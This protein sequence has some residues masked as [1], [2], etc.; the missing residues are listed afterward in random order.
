MGWGKQFIKFAKSTFKDLL[1][2]MLGIYILKCN[3]KIFNDW[4]YKNMHPLVV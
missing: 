2:G 4:I 1:V 3:K